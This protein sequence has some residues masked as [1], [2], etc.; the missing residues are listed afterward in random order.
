MD[1]QMDTETK[2][3]TMDTQTCYLAQE[4]PYLLLAEGG[5]AL[6]QVAHSV[7]H[8]AWGQ[9]SCQAFLC[10]H[11]S[12]RVPAEGHHTWDRSVGGASWNNST[13]Y[14]TMTPHP[15]PD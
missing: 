7:L 15:L 6:P 10:P 1:R 2:E 9:H 13:S 8:T 5:V 3:I 12:G 14:L 4:A 11:W